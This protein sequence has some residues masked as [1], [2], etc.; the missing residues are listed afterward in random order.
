[1]TE[2]IVTK[3]EQFIAEQRASQPELKCVNV[4]VEDEAAAAQLAE[5]LQ[6]AGWCASVDRG[7]VFGREANEMRLAELVRVELWSS[8][9]E[10]P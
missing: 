9:E 5:A 8:L 10:E 1:M 6:A 3:F 4:Q 7:L 2:E